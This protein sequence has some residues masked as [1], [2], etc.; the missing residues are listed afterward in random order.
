M[1]SSKIL[2]HFFEEADGVQVTEKG[3][4]KDQS[5]FYLLPG[6]GSEKVM[7]D[8]NTYLPKTEE[9]CTNYQDNQHYHEHEYYN[10][11]FT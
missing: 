8:E 7:K 3:G 5:L 4:K 10:F 6:G 11:K 1:Q 9:L 2:A